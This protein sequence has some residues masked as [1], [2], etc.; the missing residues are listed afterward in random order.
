MTDQP[1]AVRVDAHQRYGSTSGSR[2]NSTIAVLLIIAG[3]LVRILSYVYSQNAG[4]DAWAHIALAAMWLR[5]PVFKV[6]F[7]A[8]PPGHF[9]LIGLT[10]LVIHDVITAGRLL[11][12]VLGIGSLWVVWRL[13]VK[14]YGGTA[15]ILSLA[16][17][18]FYSLHIGYSTTSSAEVSYL[19]FLLTGLLFYFSYAESRHILYLAVAGILFSISES[20]R[21]ESWIVFGASFIVL[22]LMDRRILGLRQ[23]SE[24]LRSLATFGVTG[25]AWP[26]FMMAYCWRV[27]RDPMYLVHWNK[28]RVVQMMRTVPFSHQL[29]VMPLALL[30][31]LCPLAICAAVYGIAKSLTW[32]LKGV[33]A[34]LTLFFGGV[35]AYELLTSGLLATPRYSIT[36]GAMLAI[37]AGYGFEVACEKLTPQR[38][39]LARTAVIALLCLNA[40]L[41]LLGSEIPN[42]FSDKLAGVSPRLRYHPRIVAVAGYLRNHLGPHDAVVID[43]Y[44]VESD[45]VAA[46]SGLPIVPGDRVYLADR[47]NQITA[48]QYIATEHPHFLV[49]AGQGTLRNS[50][51][52]PSECSGT[53]QLDGVRF[54]CTFA[55]EIYRVYELSY[56]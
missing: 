30:I 56:P 53:Q 21:Y 49:Y 55:G 29:I 41:V 5:H 19:F 11:S 4:G 35:E 43:D 15:A 33:F 20:I 42:R 10:S 39:I 36:L 47:K 52:L 23:L 18:V 9:W 7:D 44:N 54:R 46:A 27:Y 22:P 51:A 38:M 13:A 45:I 24:H 17:F 16:V 14:L 25:G 32:Q 34:F 50:L 40:L 1:S 12:L 28:L 48:L 2:A 8:Y 3:A 37:L 31:S 26:A 6:V